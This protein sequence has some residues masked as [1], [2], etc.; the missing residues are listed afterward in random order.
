MLERY[1]VRPETVDRIRSSWISGA[2][3]QY[4][5]WLVEQKYDDK[6]IFRRIPLL[7]SFGDFARAHGA[8]NVEA[9]PRYIEPFIEARIAERVQGR[10]SAERLKRISKDIRNP[11]Q[12]MLRLVVAG[13]NVKRHRIAENPFEDLAPGFFVSL[14]QE[15]GLR[16]PSITHYSLPA[17]VASYLQSI[18]FHDLRHLSAPVLSGFFPEFS[19]RGGEPAFAM[20]AVCCVFSFGTC[21]GRK[22]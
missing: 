2:I 14:R 12:Q 22:S 11:I 8:E 5:T 9:L 13:F 7:V 6:S 17:S 20:H 15:R 16:E 19:K 18:Q 4:V 10:K 1:Y 3:D 21:T